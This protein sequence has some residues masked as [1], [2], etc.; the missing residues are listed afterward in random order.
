MNNMKSL[1]EN[2]FIATYSIRSEVRVDSLQTSE[3]EFDLDDIPSPIQ[4]KALGEGKVSF[5]N[6]K[7]KIEVVHYEDFI[8]QCKKPRSF[9]IGRKKCDY[10]FI[11]T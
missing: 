1:L 8:N 7:G 6:E 2:D 3:I 10:L 4:L 11:R 5:C 9:L